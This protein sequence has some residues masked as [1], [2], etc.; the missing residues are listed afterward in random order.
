MPYNELYHHGRL[1]QKWGEKNGPPYPLSRSTVRSAYGKMK[2]RKEDK[3]AREA[4][5]Q[6]KQAEKEKARLAA[7]KERVLREGTASEVLKYKNELTIQEL[8]NAINRIRLTNELSQLSSREIQSNMQKFDKY[9]QGLKTLTQWGR[10][11]TE[12]WNL[13]VD[14]YNATDEGKKKPMTKIGSGGEGDKKKKK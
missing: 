6:R 7:D 5:A 14:V 12:T 9:M 11:G 3:R 10:I 4:E 8:Q 2:Q 13:I 1:G